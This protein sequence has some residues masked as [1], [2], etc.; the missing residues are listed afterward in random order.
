M[1]TII[2]A[3]GVAIEVAVLLRVMLRPHREPASRIAWVAVIAALPAVGVIA[4]LLFGE[5]DIGRGRLEMLRKIERDMPPAGPEEGIGQAN[6]TAGIPER[7]E[8]LF[9]FGR[10]VS[11]FEPVAGN[12][13]QLQA[14]SNTAIA[15]MVADIDAA[16]EHVHVLFYIWLSDGNGGRIAAALQRAVARG[17]VCRAL[18][19]GLGSRALLKSPL[20]RAMQAA[21]V[22][23]GV[24]LALKHPLLRAPFRRID[25]RNHRK[26]VVIDHTITYCGSQNCADP[27]FRVKAR[28]APWVDVMLRLEGPIARQNQRLFAIDWMCSTSENLD[29]LMRAPWPAA[30]PGFPAQ[31]IATGP[32]AGYSAMPETFVSLIYCARRELTISTPYF[33]PDESMLNALCSAGHRGVK[34]TIVFPARNDSWIVA[35]ASRSYYADLLEAG[36]EIHEY[37]GGLLHAKTLTLDGET[38]LIGSANMDRRSFE[39][40]YENN[41]L[42]YDAA[43]TGALHDRQR[44]YLERSSPVTRAAVEAWSMPRR[45]WN[46]SL[47]LLGPIL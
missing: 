37:V 6:L 22:K 42:L 1:S 40:N 18:V 2:L 14:D 13:A 46:N 27:E 3:A 16:K 44:E 23:T 38:T 34:T 7:Y 26:I 17:V 19:D 33:V 36:V 11:G 47:A 20:W 45:F 29:D 12:S 9:R 5:L 41:I 32:T 39:L 25:L 4:Y 10:S 28:F 30:R 43:L 24:A 15:A 35:G 31:V 8:S 21:G